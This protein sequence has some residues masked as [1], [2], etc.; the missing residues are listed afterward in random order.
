MRDAMVVLNKDLKE[1]FKARESKRWTIT[2]IVI[3]LGIF[4]I[5]LPL[6]MI[7]AWTTTIVPAFFLL[8]LPV[9][10]ANALTADSFAG[11]RERKTLE[12]L[13]ATR[14][15]DR[16]IFLGK[17]A[18]ATLYAWGMTVAAMLVSLIAVN[19]ARPGHGIFLFP[20][21]VVL[22]GIVGS[23]LA[24]VLV[25][26]VG[27]FISLRAKS[28]R[29]AQQVWSIVFLAVFFGIGF[30]L[31]MLINALP[32]SSVVGAEQAFLNANVGLITAGALFVMLI[33]DAILLG[34]GINRF[35][36]AR[37]ILD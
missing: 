1:W 8:F 26:G 13:L 11:E 15:P 7:D 30:G 17:V 35:Q 21:D 34:I 6:Q 31:P 16:S 28:V 12:T 5:M 19:V 20:G 2:S 4:G 33:I 32:R 37:L 29:A 36:R 23:L 18:A 27:V 22:I 14:L 9:F 25:V 10:T 3:S 24:S